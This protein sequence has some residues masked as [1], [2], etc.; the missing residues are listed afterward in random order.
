[1]AR[2]GPMIANP[3]LP[4]VAACRRWLMTEIGRQERGEDPQP[5]TMPDPLPPTRE[6]ATLSPEVARD[7]DALELPTIVA[8]DEDCI[9][10]AN[11]AGAAL[12]GWDVD[13]L[14]GRR[15]LAF[16]PP[17]LRQAHLARMSRYLGTANGADGEAT[18]AIPVLRRD[19]TR[20]DVEIVIHVLP[21]GSGRLAV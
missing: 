7:V 2:H 4:E 5:W 10:H 14:V 6:P 12:L 19:G 11:R 15:L 9:T 18:L 16:I 17:E 1:M 13:A 21:L 8:D 3:C 20:A